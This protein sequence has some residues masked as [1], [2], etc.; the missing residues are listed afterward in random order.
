MPR[1]PNATV[2]DH[3]AIVARLRESRTAVARELMHPLIEF[4]RIGRAHAGEIEKL[5]ILMVVAVRTA[6]HEE[7]RG[8]SADQVTSGELPSLPT[9]GINMRSIADSLDMP[10][11]TVRRKVGEMI[12]A[13][14]IERRGDTLA[15]TPQSIPVFDPVILAM[16]ELAGRNYAAVAKLLAGDA[17]A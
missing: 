13:G 5:L 12:D 3:S 8:Y 4:L 17:E 2:A 15:V 1:T 11:E 9:R 16:H 10:R 6:E 14:W 7:F